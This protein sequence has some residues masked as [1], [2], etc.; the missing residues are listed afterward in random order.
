MSASST[1][2]TQLVEA[3]LSPDFYPH[4]VEVITTIETHI[5]IVFL[6]GRYAYK[7]KKPVNMTLKP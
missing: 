5:S 4:P 3:L 1:H 2:F 6:T 7:L